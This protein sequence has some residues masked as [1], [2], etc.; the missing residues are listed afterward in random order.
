MICG[1]YDCR[2]RRV[3]M[4]ARITR[5]GCFYHQEGGDFV[6]KLPRIL[7]TDEIFDFK[8]ITDFID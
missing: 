5:S 4:I 1:I 2:S 8:N 7:M 6:Y 3:L